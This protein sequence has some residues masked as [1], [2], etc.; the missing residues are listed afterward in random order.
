MEVA[1]YARVSSE[2]QDIENSVS[3]Q[4]RA[5]HKYAL[6]REYTV[7]A[8]Y[9]DEAESGKSAN[10]PAFQD[11]IRDAKN[12]P[13]PF[14]GI[15]VWKLSRFARDIET[16]IV[17]KSLLKKQ[18]VKVISINEQF[19]D[20]PSGFLYEHMMEVIDDFYSRNLSQDVTRGM[21]EVAQRGFWVASGVPYGFKR[22]KVDDG[23]S[24]R[25]K[26]EIEMDYAT[27]VKRIFDQAGRSVGVKKIAADLNEDGVPS[28]TGKKWGRSHVH[29]IL[30]NEVY[31]GTLVWGVG[32]PD[33]EPSQPAVRVE[34]A[35]PKLVTKKLFRRVRSSLASRSPKLLPPRSVTSQYLLSNLVKCG[36]CKSTM[37]GLAA[38]S[39]KYHYYTCA[40]RYRTG[41]CA[42]R[43]IPVAQLDTV[44]LDAIRTK[45]LQPDHMQKLVKLVE[46]EQRALRK[47]SHTK[48]RTL[49][50]SL[51]DVERRLAKNYEALES[52]SVSIDDLAPRIRELRGDQK[53]LVASIR[54]S[55]SPDRKTNVPS[56][57]DITHALENFGDVM[58][59]GS[60]GEQKEF[61]RG[62]VTQVVKSDDRALIRYRLPDGKSAR[63]RDVL[64]IVP[65]GGAGG[66]R[67]LY[68]FNAIE[69]LSQVSYSPVF[70]RGGRFNDC[71]FTLFEMP[72]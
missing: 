33:H 70:M 57:D 4:M 58:S 60:Q 48:V 8:E 21:R 24:Q 16:S 38:K 65:H 47:E 50:K 71:D 72:N 15:L 42:T 29:A 68:L 1:L 32:R 2:K 6:D 55:K 14:T 12:S 66:I 61:V 18:G 39:G 56:V 20:S 7:V 26:L 19:D 9:V 28:P 34:N 43:A 17:Y 63:Q 40:N 36:K 51:S 3:A 10:R 25:S 67:T 30:K 44:V 59:T 45:I 49:T 46:K 64:D 69:A 23:S 5:L 35:F 54:D 62:L 27:V 41:D 37:F 53:D 13:P 11:M 31:I 52:G 22:V